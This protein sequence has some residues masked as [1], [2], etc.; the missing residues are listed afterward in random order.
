MYCIASKRVTQ[1]S[2]LITGVYEATNE[3][4]Y[5]H[6]VAITLTMPRKQ[7][8][9]GYTYFKYSYSYASLDLTK[10]DKASLYTNST[11]LQASPCVGFY[12]KVESSS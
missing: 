12:S 5:T 4:L 6:I 8:A 10:A 2:I 11:C 3:R 1:K 7:S 9:S